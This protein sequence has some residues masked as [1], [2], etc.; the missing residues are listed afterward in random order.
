[1]SN[2]SPGLALRDEEGDRVGLPRAWG[3][4][5]KQETRKLVVVWLVCMHW[6]RQGCMYRQRVGRKG[7]G[8]QAADALRPQHP[9]L[10]ERM[11]GRADQII[12]PAVASS[13]R[14]AGTS[15]CAGYA[16][17]TDAKTANF[18]YSIQ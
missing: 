12:S 4:I 10:T 9:L 14:P 16:P 5:D 17:C 1:V 8:H 18:K 2:F 3:G 6:S 15:V 11:P 7:M 13:W